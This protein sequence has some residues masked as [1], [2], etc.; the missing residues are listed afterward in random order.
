[1]KRGA[2]PM[3]RSSPFSILTVLLIFSMKRYGVFMVSVPLV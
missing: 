3:V 1:M 2:V